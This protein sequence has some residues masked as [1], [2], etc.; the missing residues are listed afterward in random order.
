MLPDAEWAQAEMAKELELVTRSVKR[1][2]DTPEERPAKKMYQRRLTLEEA[3]PT[4]ERWEPVYHPKVPEGAL[5]ASENGVIRNAKTLKELKPRSDDSERQRIQFKKERYFIDEL[6][7]SAYLEWE[8]GKIKHVNGDMGDDNVSNLHVTSIYDDCPVPWLED[9]LE[10][11]ITV[12]RYYKQ[13]YKGPEP[14]EPNTEEWRTLPEWHGYTVSNFGKCKSPK[15]Y[16]LS[17]QSVKIYAPD[18]TI[19]S[20][21]VLRMVAEVFVPVPFQD[22]YDARPKNGR[23]DDARAENIEWYMH[24]HYDP[25][26]PDNKLYVRAGIRRKKRELVAKFAKSVLDQV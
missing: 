17:T 4:L 15:G 23:W 1:E 7:A 8:E 11:I 25:T 22:V 10:P 6:V 19:T 9:Y 14:Y 21:S 20:K 2:N 24:R 13:F 12:R 3:L 18:R 16:E 26:S 5:E